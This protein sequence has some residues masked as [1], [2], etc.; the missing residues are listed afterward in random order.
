MTC[1]DARHRVLAADMSALRGEADRV[2]R[3]HLDS[4]PACSADAS[5]VLGET[6]RLGAALAARARQ[7]KIRRASR[8]RST[9]VLAPIGVAAAIILIVV[10]RRISNGPAASTPIVATRV[11]SALNTSVSD[12]DTDLVSPPHV[13]GNQSPGRHATK[14]AAQR[15]RPHASSRAERV[16]RTPITAGNVFVDQAMPEVGVTVGDNQRA[17]II[18]TSNPKITVVW[19]SRGQQ[20]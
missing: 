12:G 5:L 6:A 8:R 7:P 4:C 20:P 15:Q 1:A 17:A 19:L 3:A 16:I 14:T 13:G 11:A 2:L 9:F 10:T 18:A